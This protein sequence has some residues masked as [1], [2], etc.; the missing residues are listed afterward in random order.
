MPHETESIIELKRYERLIDVV[1]TDKV[2]GVIK[3]LLELNDLVQIKMIKN[4]IKLNFF[5]MVFLVENVG[6]E[7]ILY[8]SL[9]Y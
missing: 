3:Y 1:S 9:K 8:C 2:I 5:S 6:P 4:I 7:Y